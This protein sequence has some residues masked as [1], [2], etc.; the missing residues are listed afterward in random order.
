MNFDFTTTRED[1]DNTID[2]WALTTTSGVTLWSS[3][4]LT[5]CVPIT[6]SSFSSL[7][8]TGYS[9]TGNQLFHVTKEDLTPPITILSNTMYTVPTINIY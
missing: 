9:S 7:T 2:D 1:W 3:D 4:D 6:I 5:F 8:I